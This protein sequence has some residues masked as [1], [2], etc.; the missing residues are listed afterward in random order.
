MLT[1]GNVLGDFNPLPDRPESKCPRE[2]EVL[3]TLLEKEKMLVTSIFFFSN[4]VC[5]ILSMA[6]IVNLSIFHYCLLQML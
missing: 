2:R 6:E 4:N 5:F 1:L 3:E